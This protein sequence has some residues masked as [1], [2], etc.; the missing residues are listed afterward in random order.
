[1][2]VLN[3]IRENKTLMAE[4][5]AKRGIQDGAA[6]LDQAIGLDDQRK[7]TK[8]E[9]DATLTESNTLAKQIGMLMKEGKRDEAESIKARTSELKSTSKELSE[10]LSN[11]EQELQAL[12]YNIPNVPNELVPS[13]KNEDDNITTFTVDHLTELPAGSQPH[14]E[15]IKEYDIVD[16]EMG[17][18]VT[19]AGF[20]FYK[21]Q[22]AR[23]QRAL[24]N[25]F[26]DEAISAGYFEVQPPIVINEAS[27]YGTGQ[28]PDKEGQMYHATADDLYLIPTAEVPITNM[29]RDVI[30]DESQLP[31]KNVAHT[32]CFRREAGSWG[33][34]VRGLNR[35]HQFDKV[36]IVHIEHPDN[37][38]AALK[39]MC[40]HVESLLKKL[41]LPYRILRLCGGDLG[42]TSAITYDFEVY[43]AA[44][45]K[46]L[47]CS[48]VSNFETYQSNRL[49]LRFK[50]KDNKKQLLHTLNGSAL[51]LPR[52]LAALLENNQQA[53]GIMVPEVLRPYTGFDKIVK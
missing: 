53:D 27:G 40:D 29:Y 8:S 51:A 17:V 43:S 37:S 14:W 52:I 23:M 15:L 5:L 3:D 10:Q 46:W 18:K 25:F 36:E 16:F 7:Q 30:L 38:Y 6:L 45:E 12:L 19:G 48:S 50:D 20:P 49:K 32:P 22:G 21:G 39:E 31:I 11:I 42:F 47:E 44:Q 13:G 35:L 24:I 2:L 28:L 33:A 26:L 41:N 4:R 1:M 34:H 9:L